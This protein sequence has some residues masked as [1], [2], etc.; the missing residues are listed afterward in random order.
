MIT[1]SSK[2]ARNIAESVKRHN[3]IA[4]QVACKIA[5]SR[6]AFGLYCF[7]VSLQD[8]A[9]KMLF[10]LLP[11]FTQTFVQVLS[12]S[13]CPTVDCGL[14]MEVLKVRNKLVHLTSCF[15]RYR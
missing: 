11:Q 12:L 1:F 8:V 4:R 10:P 7:V 5:K 6:T 2:V 15:R 14:K 9:K 13:D 3:K